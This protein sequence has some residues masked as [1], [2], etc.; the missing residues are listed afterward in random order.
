MGWGKRAVGPVC[1]QPRAKRSGALGEC[2]EG[3]P[4]P[5]RAKALRSREYISRNSLIFILRYMMAN[6]SDEVKRKANYYPKL[7]I[8]LLCANDQF[9]IIS[10]ALGIDIGVCGMLLDELTARLHIVAHQH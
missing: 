1:D 5:V 9:G 6:K 2:W 4:R 8:R 7:A 10:D 3:T